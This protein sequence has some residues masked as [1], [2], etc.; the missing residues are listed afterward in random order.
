MSDE[1]VKPDF[2]VLFDAENA[3]HRK[4]LCGWKKDK[5]A[6][7]WDKVKSQF[8]IFRIQKKRGRKVFGTAA[9]AG[10]KRFL[11]QIM[12]KVLGSDTPNWAQEAGSCVG[13]GARN[14][15]DYLSCTN[16]FILNKSE[17]FRP[18]HVPY[19]Y[20]CMRVFIGRENGVNFGGED[21]G[22]GSFMADSVRKYGV[23][24]CD[25]PNV[26]EYRGQASL[27]RKW[28]APPGPPK[29]F[30]P[31]AQ[32][33]LVKQTARITTWDQL[34]EA[35]VNGYPCTIASMLSVQMKPNSE[36]FHEETREGWAHQMCI[37]GIDDEWKDP[38]VIIR[39][40]W[41]D[42][43]GRIKDFYTGEE[44]PIGCIRVRKSVIERFLRDPDTEVFA[45]SQFDGFPEQRY[46]LDRRLFDLF[47]N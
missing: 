34:V 11:H 21:G 41:A 47:G 29:E 6:E 23:L 44:L 45:F 46:E 37:I 38:Y 20:G 9:G 43:H 17:K 2:G 16:I 33:Y 7:G 25:E 5:V 35:I 19:H 30:I 27:A 13:E 3:E 18:S 32:K 10:K 12:R 14:A 26:P 31:L 24:F 40:S 8:P 36:G 4:N 39:N 42:V 22:I 28:G 1:M 15:S